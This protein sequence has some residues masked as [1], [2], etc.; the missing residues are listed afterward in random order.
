MP[1]FAAAPAPVR[2]GV[3]QSAARGPVCLRAGPDSV[4]PSMA[5]RR[6]LFR[7]QVRQRI[8]AAAGGVPPRG[9]WLGHRWGEWGDDGGFSGNAFLPAPAVRLL[10]DAEAADVP[11]KMEAAAFVGDPSKPLIILLS[12]MGAKQKHMD[13]ISQYYVERGYEVVSFLNGMSTA[14]IPRASQAQAKRIEDLLTAQPDGRPV[15]VHA[16]SIGTGIYGFVLDNLRRD[17]ELFNKIK[18]NVAGVILDSGPAMIFPKDV[19]VGLHSVCPTVS[20]KVWNAVADALFWVT[21]ARSSFEIAEQALHRLHFP[22]PQMYFASS[23]DKVIRGLQERMSIFMETNRQRGL[24]VYHQFWEKS[25]HATHFKIHTE[26][27]SQRLEDFM[28]RCL[29]FRGEKAKPSL[30]PAN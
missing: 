21:K 19:A 5:A 16:F 7:M 25:A 14:L 1:A 26:E 4:P 30:A 2:P 9:P 15:F 11:V 27:Y 10:A 20:R 6:R 24:E 13:K 18:N 23:D 12:W 8:L 17:I 3:R 28:K 22:T 29:E